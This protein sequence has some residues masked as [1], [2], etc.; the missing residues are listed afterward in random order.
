M[1]RLPKRF[2]RFLI[3]LSVMLAL[4]L[5]P[6]GLLVIQLA[7]Y[8]LSI[9]SPHDPAVLGYSPTEVV[10]E[11]TGGFVMSRYRIK[12]HW[13]D[14]FLAGNP[15]QRNDDGYDAV[16]VITDLSGDMIA[17]ISHWNGNP[18]IVVTPAGITGSDGI[19]WKAAP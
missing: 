5:I 17:R 14:R 10:A 1:K 19:E 8:Y 16:I 2:K 9:G 3:V 18:K 11:S 13:L 15:H 7:G 6:V 12:A 4:F